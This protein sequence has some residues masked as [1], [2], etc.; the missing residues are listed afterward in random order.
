MPAL[1]AAA[2]IPFRKTFFDGSSPRVISSR[3]FAICFVPLPFAEAG[4]DGPPP[5]PQATV[6]IKAA[7]NEVPRIGRTPAARMGRHS[8][9]GARGAAEAVGLRRGGTA[10]AEGFRLEAHRHL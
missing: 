9:R 10:P 1:S 3:R 4:V 2:R 6:A 5:P 8:I 7:R